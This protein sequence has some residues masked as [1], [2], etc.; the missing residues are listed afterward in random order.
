MCLKKHWMIAR[1]W[2]Q[3][4]VNGIEKS[5]YIFLQWYFFKNY[6]YEDNVFKLKMFFGLKFL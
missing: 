2:S 4:S 3:N 6:F 1:V 5:F